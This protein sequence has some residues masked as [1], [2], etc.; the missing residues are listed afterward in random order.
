MIIRPT[1][2]LIEIDIEFNFKIFKSVEVDLNHV[3]K[4]GRSQFTA[5]EVALFTQRVLQGKKMQPSAVK[6]FDKE[7]CSYFVRREL[8]NGKAYK[9]VFCICSDRPDTIGVITL[10]RVKGKA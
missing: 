1:L 6:S 2:E 7:V 8:W 10:F 5:F 4:Y 3:N 9:I